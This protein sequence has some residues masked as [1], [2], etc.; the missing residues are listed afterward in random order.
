MVPCSHNLGFFEGNDI[1]IGNKR[2][3]C[4]PVVFVVSVILLSYRI[5]LCLGYWLWLCL[6]LGKPKLL[7][8]FEIGANVPALDTRMACVKTQI[9]PDNK[10]IFVEPSN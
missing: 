9:L 3:K 6:G 5:Y 2:I 8:H 7:G 10:V 1:L 4:F